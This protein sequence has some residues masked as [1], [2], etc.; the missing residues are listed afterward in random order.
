[1]HSK[2]INLVFYVGKFQG[3][4]ACKKNSNLALREQTHACLSR[5]IQ[6]KKWLPI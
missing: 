5:L 2:K 6:Y 1:M 3:H 4:T